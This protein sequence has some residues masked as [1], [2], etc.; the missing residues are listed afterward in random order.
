MLAATTRGTPG[1]AAP[2]LVN[3]D[4]TTLRTAGATLHVTFSLNVSAGD[5]PV[6]RGRGLLVV[7]EGSAATPPTI[8]AH[9]RRA[10]VELGATGGRR[11]VSADAAGPQ[12]VPAPLALAGSVPGAIAPAV[13]KLVSE[14]HTTAK[15]PFNPF[16]TPGVSA[17]EAH[18]KLASRSRAATRST[19]SAS[20]WTLASSGAPAAMKPCFTSTARRP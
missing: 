20:R 4:G 2:A 15:I 18:F 9:R 12:L 1:S 16:E 7:D 8:L 6:A 3:V 17:V 19:A 13:C 11:L 14:G 5:V 10:A